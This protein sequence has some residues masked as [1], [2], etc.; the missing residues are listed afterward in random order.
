MNLDLKYSDKLNADIYRLGFL[1]FLLRTIFPPLKFLFLVF[2][3][4]S[5]AIFVNRDLVHIRLSNLKKILLP[6]LLMLFYTIG[7]MLSANSYDIVLNE[8]L[9]IAVLLFYVVVFSV[10]F[11]IFD[12]RFFKLSAILLLAIGIIAIA[13]MILIINGLTIPLSQFLFA[14]QLNKLSL[15]SDNNYYSLYFILG[16]AISFFLKSKDRINALLFFSSSSVFLI[17]IILCFSR[18]GYIGLLLLLVLLPLTLLGNEKKLKSTLVSFYTFLISVFITSAVLIYSFRFQLYQ[19]DVRTGIISRNLYDLSSIYKIDESSPV[20]TRDLW[21]RVS[22]EFWSKYEKEP[23]NQIYNGDFDYNLEFWSYTSSLNDSVIQN[24]KFENNKKYLE[25]E[26]YKGVG[27]FQ[28]VYNGR[29]IYFHRDVRYKLNFD[30]RIVLGE[31]IPFKVGWWVLD[32]GQRVHD[33]PKTITELADGWK[34]CEVI[35]V[36]K[37]DHIKPLGFINSMQAGSIINI[38][39]ISISTV[40]T[41][42]PFLYSDQIQE[43][44]ATDTVRIEHNDLFGRRTEMWKFAIKLWKDEYSLKNKIFGKG[45]DYLPMYGSHFNNNED[46]YTYPHNPVISSFLYAGLIGGSFHIYF[47]LM[48]FW[49]YWKHRRKL[50]PAFSIYVFVFIFTMFSGNSHFSVN[51]FAFLSFVPF[52]HKIFSEQVMAARLD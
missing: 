10:R 35:F 36:F 7:L 38:R 25:I 50:F 20:F 34:N 30:L 51:L 21:E 13:R 29:P 1:F 39:D 37:E 41:I 46:R 8:L 43:N 23:D 12:Y 48:V 49:L 22:E 44:Y 6:L 24:L 17:N 4:L 31:G 15:V 9:T 2:A 26:R 18:R 52:I 11:D 14:T 32:S 19:Y 3:V 45:F 40:D 42:P 33:L 47:L 16:I 28:L 27:F 5:L